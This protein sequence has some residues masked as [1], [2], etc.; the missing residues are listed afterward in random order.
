MVCKIDSS[1]RVFQSFAKFLVKKFLYDYG[2][3]MMLIKDREKQ[4]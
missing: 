3:Y 4:L 2:S 1:I